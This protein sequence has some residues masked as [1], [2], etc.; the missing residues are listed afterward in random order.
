LLQKLELDET[1]DEIDEAMIIPCSQKKEGSQKNESLS[2]LLLRLRNEETCLR[3]EKNKLT[4]QKEELLQRAN[5]EIISHKSNI[6][7]LKTE[8]AEL[9]ADCEALAASLDSET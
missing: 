8:I 4:A 9:K 3:E 5:I 6:G 7:Q 1:C 2:S